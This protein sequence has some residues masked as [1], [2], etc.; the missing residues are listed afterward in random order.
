MQKQYVFDCSSGATQGDHED[1]EEGQTTPSREQHHHHHHRHH[2]PQRRSWLGNP[3]DL[4]VHA[5]YH[6]T[7]QKSDDVLDVLDVLPIRHGCAKRT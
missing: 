6:T 5:H 3:L 2:H 4:C 1:A 7:I